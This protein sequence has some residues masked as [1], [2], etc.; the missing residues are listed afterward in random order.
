MLQVSRLEAI[1]RCPA[2]GEKL[3]WDERRCAGCARTFRVR[4]SLV[5]LREPTEMEMQHRREIELHE[6]LV[7]DY[8]TRY[9]P[10]FS[11]VYSQ[12]W[13]EQFLA[14]LPQRCELVLDCGCGTGELVRALRE[15]CGVV[16][17]LD[18]SADML[19]EGRASLGDP[20]NVVWI[21]SPGERLPLE[22][23]IFDAVCF[24][25]ALHHMADEVSALREA[26][27]VL[28]PGGTLVLSEPNDDSVLLRIPRRLANRHSKRFGND[29]KAF[30]SKPWLE[31]IESVG[32]RVT[33]TKFF[34]YLSQPLCG[35]SDLLP[36]MRFLPASR[37]IARG[38]V[39]FDELCSGLP[40]IRSQSFDL[41]VGASKPA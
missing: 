10:P 15:V 17:A 19:E 21:A 30:R 8:R 40:A 2:C 33:S 25:G 35:M 16:V 12:Y 26:H 36:L 28:K 1:L 9:R 39:R 22:S 31:T 32:F 24:R 23:A 14:R 41:I 6:T 38:L 4:D 27:R 13:N 18:L 11:E 3:R 29:H 34:S 37:R 7:S 5:D 20:D